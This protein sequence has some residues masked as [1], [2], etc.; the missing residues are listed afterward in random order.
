MINFLVTADG[1]FGIRDY[2][3]WRA[4]ALA[5]RVS[6][7]HYDDLARLTQI[8]SGAVVFAA[9]DQANAAATTIVAQIHDQVTAANPAM[10]VL[11]DPRRVL[12]RLALLDRL[13]EERFNHF[14]AI[15][16]TDIRA[17]LR[18]PVFVRSEREHTGSLT[19]VLGDRRAL[20]RALGVLVLRGLR[21]AELLIVEYLE[22]AD[23]D[24]VYRKYS[25]MRIG[26][27]IVPRHL[28][29]SR[30]WITKSDDN[31]DDE[32]MVREELTYLETNPHERWLRQVFDIAQIEYGR[33]DYGFWRGVPQVWEINMNPTLARNTRLTA[34][35]GDERHRR[36]REPGRALCHQRM[37][38]AFER[39]DTSPRRDPIPIVIDARWRR[40]ITRQARSERRAATLARWREAASA[41]QIIRKATS[42]LRPVADHLAPAIARVLLRALPRVRVR[43]DHPTVSS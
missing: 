4:A 9:L 14:T 25:A 39:L 11:N 40:R 33:I 35:G 26:D 16:A 30:S 38:D 18:Y 19:P 8:E 15:R 6:V 32:A 23:R 13:H 24:G 27:V 36:L 22:T 17:R 34:A 37:L 1:S 5:D 3:R 2:L 7:V 43:R 42:A 20:D 10:P 12:R 21:L 28:H 29:A 41:H 31:L